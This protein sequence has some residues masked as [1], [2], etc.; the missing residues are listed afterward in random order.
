MKPPGLRGEPVGWALPT[1]TE[2]CGGR[3]PPYNVTELELKKEI[4]TERPPGGDDVSA[5]PDKLVPSPGLKSPCVQS[6]V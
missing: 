6:S 1:V 2:S 3:C 4:H 5:I